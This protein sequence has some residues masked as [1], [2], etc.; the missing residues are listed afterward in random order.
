MARR[1]KRFSPAD[2]TYDLWSR[3]L[4]GQLI[5]QAAAAGVGGRR[6]RR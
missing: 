1:A 4:T 2:Q 6:S 3:M 5:T